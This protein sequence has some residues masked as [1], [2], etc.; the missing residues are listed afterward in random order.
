MLS[1]EVSL[2]RW[3]KSQVNTRVTCLRGCVWAMETMRSVISIGSCY[4]E[5]SLSL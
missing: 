1:G 3:T 5:K 2:Q 4:A